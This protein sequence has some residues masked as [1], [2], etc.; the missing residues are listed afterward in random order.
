MAHRHKDSRVKWTTTVDDAAV[1]T[2]AGRVSK[3]E[4]DV[5]TLLAAAGGGG[6]TTPIP[7]DPPVPPP[8]DITAPVISG[9]TITVTGQTT[10]TVSWVTN[11]AATGLV[12]Y[13][14][15]TSYGSQTAAT[16]SGTSHSRNLTGLTAGTL[17]HAQVQA[18]DTAGNGPTL[19]SDRT[20]TTA[21]T[22]PPPSAGV[23]GFGSQVTGGTGQ[24][25]VHVTNLNDTGAGSFRAALGSNRRIVFDVAG[26]ITLASSTPETAYSNFT[27]DGSTAPGSGITF[28]GWP[29]VFAGCTNF[30]IKHL[31]FR[32]QDRPGT[33]DSLTIKDGCTSFVVDHCSMSGATDGSL[34][35]T[36][37]CTDASIQ[38]C[39]LG[40][41]T[42]VS[43][44]A[45]RCERITWHHNLFWEG[46]S[47]LPQIGSSA[48]PKVGT[49]LTADVRCN[50]I[51]APVAGLYG[52]VVA[53]DETTN[54]VR[55][56]YFLSPGRTGVNYAVNTG[57]GGT[58]YSSGNFDKR[59]GSTAT[60]FP[61]SEVTVADPFQVTME[62]TA[63]L[64]ASAVVAGAGCR[65]G[66]LDAADAARIANVQAGL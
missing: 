22:V 63:Q 6:G 23:E 64:A 29:V 31:R 2:L 5:K 41:N 7:N 56:Y 9:I 28:R 57:S 44:T 3:L 24:T 30:I 51:W 37:D 65:V 55:N 13:G 52:T 45:F 38:W 34:D 12:S 47:R 19:S 58:A 15:T 33:G 35:I 49:D 8:P 59:G 1:A 40:D 60:S 62:A 54:V 11:E 43:L 17:Y 21:Q 25:E 26:T 48:V 42:S 53:G 32:D 61:A 10:A 14:L 4:A 18:T 20:F 50:L 36:T 27:I 16:S 39:L 46:V 66:G